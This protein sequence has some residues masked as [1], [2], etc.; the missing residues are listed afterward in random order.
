[1]HRRTFLAQSIAALTLSALKSNQLMAQPIKFP[2]DP[3]Q[4][5]VASGDPEPDGIVLWTRLALDPLVPN[6]GMDEKAVDVRWEVANDP[7]M[8]EIIQHGRIT[9]LPELGHSV[10]VEVRGLSPY[11]DYFYRFHAGGVTSPTGHAKTAPA[12]DASLS[13]LRFSFASC[14]NYEQGYYVAHQDMAKADLDLVVFLGDYIYERCGRRADLVRHHP[15]DDIRTLEEYRRQYALYK[16]DADL[17]A[18]HQAHTWIVTPDDHEVENNWAGDRSPRLTDLDFLRRRTAAY[19]AYYENMPLRLSAKPDRSHIQIYRSIP[20]GR[21]A[22]FTVLD[23]RQFRTV[24]PCGD[25][26]KNCDA[27]F[28]P[29]AT[30]MGPH[31]ETWFGKALSRSSAQWNLVANQVMVTQKA[32]PTANGSFAYNMDGWDG[33]VEARN[34]LF[35]YLDTQRPRNPVFLTGDAHQTWV[36]DL[37]LDFSQQDSRI[38]ASELVGTSISSAGNGAPHSPHYEQIMASNPHMVYNSFLRGYFICEVDAKA[39][40]SEL[41]VADKVSSPHEPVKPIAT[42]LIESDRKGIRQDG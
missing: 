34:R 5:G 39:M 27:R 38:V 9:A 7:E 26:Q 31:Q 29:H 37:K 42:F 6:S 15:V 35:R 33:Y 11:H 19:Q 41:R 20:Y 30:M 1:M 3:F 24:Q 14:Q 2:R 16:T 36:S 12:Y 40:R 10:H 25:G 13:K 17:R 32:D 23:T 28:D 21:L 18:C 22:Q 8:R 4:L